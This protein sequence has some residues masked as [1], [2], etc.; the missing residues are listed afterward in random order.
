MIYCENVKD[1]YFQIHQ[2]LLLI[3]VRKI[4]FKEDKMDNKAWM[5][6]IAE[7]FKLMCLEWI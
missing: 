5:K 3:A 7:Q 1:V 2:E 4:G 6:L